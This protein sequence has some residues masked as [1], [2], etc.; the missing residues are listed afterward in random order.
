MNTTLISKAIKALEYHT[1]QT[2][3]IESTRIIIEELKQAQAASVEPVGKI[4]N[5]GGNTGSLPEHPLLVWFGGVPPAGTELY[6][7]APPPPASQYTDIVSDGGMDPRNASRQPQP[8]QDWALD[9]EA[10]ATKEQRS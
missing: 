4:I 9:V 8:Q 3:P 7:S 10:L 2:R 1:A 5:S 6:A